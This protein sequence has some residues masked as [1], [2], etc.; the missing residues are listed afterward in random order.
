MRAR[1]PRAAAIDTAPAQALIAATARFTADWRALWPARGSVGLAVSGGPDSLAMLMLAHHAIP[2]QFEVATVDHGLRPQAADEAAMVAQLCVRFGIEHRTIKLDLAGG[3]AVQKRAR[4]ARYAALA[5]WLRERGLAA[6]VTGHHADDQA[7]T[8]VMRLNR[9]AGVRGLAGMRPRASVPGD[10]ALPLLRPLLGWRRA[11]LR[12]VIEQAGLIACDDPGNRDPR[13]ERARIRADLAG[14]GWVDAAALAIS[15]RHLAEADE[16]LDWAADGE[17]RVVEWTEAGC[18]Y[19][20]IAPRAV[21]LRVLE[22]IVSGLSGGHPRGRDLARWL[23]ALESGGAATLGG[24][25][26]DGRRLPWRFA[27]ARPHRIP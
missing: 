19:T 8:L 3:A 4:D 16:A 1:V 17:M 22:R 13:F 5:A 21:R 11:D 10:L 2:G 12:A 15:A 9:G 23:D 18:A 14:A 26:G 24:V 25:R 27:L 20:P 6:L 7:E